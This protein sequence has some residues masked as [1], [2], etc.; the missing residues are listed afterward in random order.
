MNAKERGFLLL[1]S[2]LGDP[3]RKPL[4]VAQFRTLASRMT[5]TERPLSDRDLLPTDLLALGYSRGEA[6]RIVTLLA[7]EEAL[8]R[9][10]SRGMGRACVP[11]SRISDGYPLALRKRLGLDAPGCLWAKGDLS[12]LSTQM[13]ALVGSRDLCGPNRLFSE[14]VG[15]EAARQGITLVSGNAR[16]AD[17]TAQ[18]A[19]L[20]NGGKVISVVADKLEEC[21]LRENVLYLSEDSYNLP[22]TSQRALSRNRVI[23]G[24]GYLTLVAQCDFG[25]G[26]TWDGTTRNLSKNWS[27]VFCFADGSAAVVELEQMG[28]TPITIDRLADLKALQS[29]LTQMEIT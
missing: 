7:G 23:H 2:Q 22:F 26:G 19:C 11:I 3:E 12:L 10:I 27:P 15:L 16:G 5:Q 29:N 28:A 8:E 25:A 1:T 18:D 20:A 6:E 13:I 14:R 24:L 4:T 9:Y 17:R 21:S